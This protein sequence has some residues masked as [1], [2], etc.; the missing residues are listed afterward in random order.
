MAMNLQAAAS[1]GSMIPGAGPWIA[2]AGALLSLFG[3]K[4]DPTQDPNYLAAMQALQAQQALRNQYTGQASQAG[5]EYAQDNTGYR[6][7]VDDEA[8]YLQ[9][10]PNTDQHDAAYLAQATVGGAQANQ[11]ADANLTANLASRGI[12]DSSQM[13][14]GLAQDAEARATQ[15]AQAQN[16]LADSKIRQ[17]QQNR[18]GLM[19]LLGGEANQDYG[20]QQTALGH[21]GALDSALYSDNLTLAGQNQARQ[22]ASDGETDSLFSTLG[23]AAGT[24]LAPGAGD[25]SMK[26]AALPLPT[27]DGP[28]AGR[29]GTPLFKWPMGKPITLKSA[30]KKP[31]PGISLNL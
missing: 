16:A 27:G 14:G 15:Q 6:K 10:D 8:A 7:S 17:A 4:K 28:G 26:P 18:T 9:R 2:G 3:K 24:I 1:A 12:T 30:L 29:G 31:K 20:R 23:N 11:R 13:V 5:D 21:A 25:A 22:A 19:S